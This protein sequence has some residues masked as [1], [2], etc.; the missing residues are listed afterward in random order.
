[1]NEIIENLEIQCDEI[2]LIET[3]RMSLGKI[4]IKMKNVHNDFITEIDAEQI[5]FGQEVDKILDAIGVEEVAEW[6]K[7][8][9][10]L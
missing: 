9:G 3:R 6:L 10:S 1:M 7:G 8:K 4:I 2:E 5:V